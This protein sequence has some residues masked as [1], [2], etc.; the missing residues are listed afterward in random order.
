MCPIIFKAFTSISMSGN[1]N[2]AT[3]LHMCGF[4]FSIFPF[5]I[6]FFL[7]LIFFLN[8]NIYIKKKAPG[9]ER[10]GEKAPTQHSHN[11]EAKTHVNSKGPFY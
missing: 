4:Y 8:I 2:T 3:P 9:W 6:L 7:I 10:E 1:Y 11:G 5:F